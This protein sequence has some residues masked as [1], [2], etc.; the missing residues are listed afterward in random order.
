MSVIQVDD[1]QFV[2]YIS[3]KEIDHAIKKV[4]EQVNEEYKN[5]VPII[6]LVLN[7]SIIF[8]ADLLKQLTVP[9]RVSCIRVSSY[10]GTKSTATV[11]NI[12]GLAEDIE[13]QR[14]LVVED[15]VDTGNTYAFLHKM[16]QEHHVKDVKIATLTFK[17]DS[18]KLPLPIDF[19]G[20]EIENK[21]IVGRG[22][23]YNGLGR[24]LREIYQVVEE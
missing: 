10:D 12:I 24:N 21:F 13:N 7:G 22:L 1:R 11:K 6:L 20:L 5:D 15:I 3:E 18:Y 8:G 2:S 19:I 14:V 17:P 4:A 9:C 23:D 16:L